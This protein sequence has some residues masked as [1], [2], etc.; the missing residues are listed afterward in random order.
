MSV[1]VA[2]FKLL[3]EP[4]VVRGS[5]CFIVQQLLA[6]LSMSLTVVIDCFVVINTSYLYSIVVQFC[7]ML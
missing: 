4:F 3:F 5:N 1:F 2:W 7:L 6:I